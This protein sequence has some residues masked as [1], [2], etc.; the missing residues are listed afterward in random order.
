LNFEEFNDF[1]Y[2]LEVNIYFETGGTLETDFYN[3]VSGNLLRDLG[4]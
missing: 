3:E 1:G 4:I 2:N